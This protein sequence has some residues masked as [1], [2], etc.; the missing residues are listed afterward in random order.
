MSIVK[1]LVFVLVF[2]FFLIFRALKLKYV[3]PQMEHE[4]F[5]QRGRLITENKG[6]TK[7]EL[8]L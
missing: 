5:C 4:Q 1:V 7:R 8:K 6:G 2:H 3:Y